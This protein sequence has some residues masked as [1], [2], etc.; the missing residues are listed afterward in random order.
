MLESQLILLCFP[1]LCK[2]STVFS[3]N[4]SGR[5]RNE[6]SGFFDLD[7]AKETNNDIIARRENK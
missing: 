5:G 7:K 2:C 4:I 6:I 3:I 1:T